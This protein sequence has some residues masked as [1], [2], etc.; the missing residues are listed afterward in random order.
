VHGPTVPQPPGA[1]HRTV[2]GVSGND[3]GRLSTKS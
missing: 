2:L 3:P 1:V